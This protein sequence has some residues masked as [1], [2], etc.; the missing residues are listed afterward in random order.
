MH[1]RL[2]IYIGHV[3]KTPYEGVVPV[4]VLVDWFVFL[5]CLLRLSGHKY[6]VTFSQR[7]K[8]SNKTKIAMITLFSFYPLFDIKFVK[9]G[10]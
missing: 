10:K 9:N 4:P 8:C 2:L 6:F 1:E 5:V 3:F 7:Q